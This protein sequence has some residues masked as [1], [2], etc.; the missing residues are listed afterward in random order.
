MLLQ[1]IIDE[2]GKYYYSKEVVDS[3][4]LIYKHKKE[5]K[6]TISKKFG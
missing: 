3:I 5:N 1:I 2:Y 4:F 6:K